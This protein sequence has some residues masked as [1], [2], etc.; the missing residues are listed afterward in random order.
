[1]QNIIEELWYG[2]IGSGSECR[3]TTKEAKEIMKYAGIHHDNLKSTLTDEQKK[4]LEKFDESD[5]ELTSTN[6]RD[7]FVYAF[8]LG[9]RIAIEIMS[10]KIE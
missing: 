6:E 4:L 1:M 3:E 8:R 9:A 2:N 10:L 5:A 7:I